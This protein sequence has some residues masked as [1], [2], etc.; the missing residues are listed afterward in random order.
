MLKK[1]IAVATFS[2]CSA[3]ASAQWAVFDGANFIKNTVTA[4]Q[5]LIDEA[6]QATQIANQM[7]QLATMTQNLQSIGSQITGAR[8][9]MLGNDAQQ[10]LAYAS[11]ARMLYGSVSSARSMMESHMRQ[12]SMS[13]LGWTGYVDQVT[14]MNKARTDDAYFLRDEEVRT[15][16]DIERQNEE[17]QALGA[18]IPQIKGNRDGLQLLNTQM[19]QLL[20]QTSQMRT[21]EAQTRANATRKAS[22]ED[23]REK[24]R[25]EE[26]RKLGEDRAKAHQDAMKS[27]EAFRQ[28]SIPARK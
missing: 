9:T 17:M 2:L 28:L 27:A 15:L 19:N 14:Q 24:A 3:S 10:L 13:G 20:A 18:Q 5:Q 22:M 7:Q 4:G 8:N 25:I 16:E 12:W 6:H 26:G 23:A 21:F 1:L 11:K